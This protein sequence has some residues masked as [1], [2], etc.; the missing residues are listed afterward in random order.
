M[1]MKV[2]GAG[3]TVISVLAVFLMAGL[4]YRDAVKISNFAAAISVSK[5]G[6]Y[7]VAADEIFDWL[8]AETD[9]RKKEMVTAW[10]IWNF[11]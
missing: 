5:V 7:V 11:N 6:T 10:A 8:E 3:D 9:L 1:H 2:S 4:E